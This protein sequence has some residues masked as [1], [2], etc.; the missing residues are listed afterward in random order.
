MG[1][2]ALEVAD[3]F[4]SHGPAWRDV[5]HDHLSLGQLKVMSAIEQCPTAT[6]GGHVLHC[7][8]CEHDVAVNHLKNRTLSIY[9]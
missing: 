4:S 7:P 1:W 9:S 5:Q 2:F 8:V 3:I 6:L